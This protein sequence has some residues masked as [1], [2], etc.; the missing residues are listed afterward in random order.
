MDRE[1]NAKDSY[2]SRCYTA[3]SGGVMMKKYSLNSLCLLLAVGLTFGCATTNNTSVDDVTDNGPY[4]ANDTCAAGPSQAPD[5][6]K[7][8]P[9]PVGVK[10]V[11][12][13]T[14][15]HRGR[16][17]TLRTEIWYPG[18]LGTGDAKKYAY[19]LKA[20]A[21]AELP[22]AYEKVKDAKTPLVFESDAHAGMDLDT[23]HG[24]YPLVVFSH[25]A[26]SIRFQSLFFTIFL[27][28]HGYI[29]V[30]PDHQ[31]NTLYDLLAYG[32]DQG[33]IAESAADRMLD[34]DFIVDHFINENKDPKSFLH[35]A[36]DTENIGFCGHSFGGFLS[37][38]EGGR[39]P[40][41]KAVISF[42]PETEI[43]P[44]WKVKPETF[45]VPF[46]ISAGEMDKTLD[47]EKQTHSFYEAASAPKYLVTL[48]RGGHYSYSDICRM[49]LSAL[50][51]ELD[52]SDGADALSDGCGT[53][54]IPYDLAHKVLRHYG[55]GFFNYYLRG[56][57]GS[58]KYLDQASAAQYG[59]ELKY[60]YEKGKDTTK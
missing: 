13:K 5:P 21:K 22:A 60:E 4:C 19:D 54:N 18:V 41:V 15:D 28:S 35:G 29:V 38:Y 58:F 37:L 44:L 1:R 40:K 49:D 47:Y 52:Y 2:I 17:R 12:L 45:P 23:A 51:K 57:T 14:K 16:P 25:G 59:K 42:A 32:Y 11:I 9:F 53:E 7:M 27:A 10:T 50:A 31:N 34:G 56:S 8:G 48:T 46:M 24:P 3:F 6:T 33:K 20:D 39:N 55:I 26:Y 30:A 43:L 36:I